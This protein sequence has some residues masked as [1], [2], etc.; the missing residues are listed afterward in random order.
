MCK[1]HCFINF[2]AA[3]HP[4]V[5][6]SSV[7]LNTFCACVSEMKESMALC[8]LWVAL[9]NVIVKNE[10][11]FAPICGVLERASVLDPTAFPTFYF[12]LFFYFDFFD[13]S[14]TWMFLS[15]SPFTVFPFQQLNFTALVSC[16][17]F[18][19]VDLLLFRL[20]NITAFAARESFNLADAKFGMHPRAMVWTSLLREE[21]GA[22]FAAGIPSL[23]ALVAFVMIQ[24]QDI[25]HSSMRN[26]SMC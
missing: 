9:Q 17:V 11:L 22:A 6:R 23:S 14:F 16:R 13:V 3:T 15:V 26:I 24:L 19:E 2:Q 7:P 4:W 18:L 8:P 20:W 12:C 10:T 5:Q 1:I 25:H 21:Q